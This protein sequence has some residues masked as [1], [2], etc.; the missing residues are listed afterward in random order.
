[1][2]TAESTQ[3]YPQ[4]VSSTRIAVPLRDVLVARL[5]DYL[6]LTR[7]RIALL[8]LLTVAV[9][10]V[11]AV[12]GNWQ[13][14]PLWHTLFG[15]AWVAAGSSA[16]NQVIERHSDARMPRTANR[17]LPAGRL[18]SWEVS[19]FGIVAGISGCAYLLAYV[20][21]TTAALALITMFL[22]L[23]V[24]TPLKR[25]SAFCTFLGAIPGAL[26]PVLG[27][28]AAG[29]GLDGGAAALFLILFLWQFPH[30]LAIA[31]LYRHEYAQAGL[32]MLPGGSAARTVTGLLA[33]GYALL[34]IPASL[35]PSRLSLGEVQAGDP[36][37]VIALVLGIG[38]AAAAFR[39]LI[40][41]S[42]QTARGLILTSLVYLPVLLIVLTWDHF[43]LLQ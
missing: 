18:S 19:L 38:Y 10:Y 31:W 11:L 28:T 6:E 16:L 34:L 36:Y 35:L 5:A 41:R 24:Y 4:A 23:G 3:P 25:R 40:R 26:P 20:N 27:W 32:R 9:G 14:G 22:Y 1:M 33:V 7:P 2:R 30:F 43:R 12:Q 42:S 37:T 17:P 8:S 13:F 15:V 39:F 29:G 21:P